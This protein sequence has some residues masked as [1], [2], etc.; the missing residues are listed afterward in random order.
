MLIVELIILR[1]KGLP[2]VLEETSLAVMSISLVN[3]LFACFFFLR[4]PRSSVDPNGLHS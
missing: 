4:F 1:V 2:L 3:L